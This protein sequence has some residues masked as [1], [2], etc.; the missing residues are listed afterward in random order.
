MKRR[1]LDKSDV[2]ISDEIVEKWQNTVNIMAELIHVPAA[3]IMKVDGSY[4]EVFRS[5]ESEGNPYKVGDREHLD[6]LYCEKVTTTKNKLLVPNALKDNDWNKNPDIKLGMISYLGFPLLWPD[7]EVFGTICVLDS[8]ENHFSEA[9][10]KL[11]LQFKDIV[12]THLELL[13]YCD[14]LEQKT[15][16]LKNVNE[17]L[18][19]SELNLRCIIEHSTEMFLWCRNEPR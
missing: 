14:D 17:Q 3:L 5:S 8:K 4:I 9:H 19:Q 12:G 13:C 6:G 7:G 10:K 1:T 16:E 15:A 11:M 18:R 2:T